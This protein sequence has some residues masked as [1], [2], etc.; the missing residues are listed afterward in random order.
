MPNG[1][2]IL[3]KFCWACESYGAEPNVDTFCAY[4]EL[5]R[6][7]KKVKVDG[8]ELYAQYGSCAFVAKRQQGGSRLEISYC[9]KNKWDRD[10]MRYWFYVWT[11][12]MTC[13]FDDGT[14][15][16]RYPMASVMSEMKPLSKVALSEEMTPKREACDR[17]FALA[18]RY[19]RGR[20]LVEEMVAS[21]YRPLGKRNP[22]LH[23]EMVNVPVRPS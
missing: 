2:L 17:V 5:Q 9:Q 6:Q 8:V 21:N 10:W 7:P 13:T 14:K 18:C 12:S 23:I 19:S 1:F 4:Y 11:Y 22:K 15:V 3:S 20:D 16:V